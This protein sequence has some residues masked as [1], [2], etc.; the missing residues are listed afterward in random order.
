MLYVG[1]SKIQFELKGSYGNRNVTFH[2]A[3][4][5]GTELGKIELT[6]EWRK[7]SFYPMDGVRLSIPPPGMV[8]LREAS[9]FHIVFENAPAEWKCR[10]KDPDR[11]CG[12]V[13]EGNLNWD[14]KYLVTKSG[15]PLKN[16]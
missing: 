6:Q 11:N 16:L 10:S 12:T 13:Q 5:S 1:K 15:I 4:G 7:F 3:G 2:R 14:G 8:E 9:L